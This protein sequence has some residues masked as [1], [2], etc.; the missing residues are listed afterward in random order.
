MIPQNLFK[1]SKSTGYWPAQGLDQWAFWAWGADYPTRWVWIM[2]RARC[3]HPPLMCWPHRHSGNKDHPRVPRACPSTGWGLPLRCTH[4]P[5]CRLGEKE[6]GCRVK[7][8]KG[9]RSYLIHFKMPLC[10]HW[11]ARFW[12]KVKGSLSTGF[13]RRKGF[14][15]KITQD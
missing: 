14:S 9:S 3:E 6:E 10:L 11:H 7:D 12:A 13:L 1:K 2:I 4:T 8:R 5:A 15:L